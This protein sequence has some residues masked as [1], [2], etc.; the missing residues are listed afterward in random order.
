MQIFPENLVSD[1]ICFHTTTVI[2]SV[3]ILYHKENIFNG[4]FSYN[5]TTSKEQLSQADMQLLINC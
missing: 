1:G 2:T 3:K 4:K 5:H